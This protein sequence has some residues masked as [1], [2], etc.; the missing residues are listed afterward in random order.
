MDPVAA[1][2]V[3]VTRSTVSSALLKEARAKGLVPFWDRFVQ[4]IFPLKF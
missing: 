4:H 2:M 1:S 3:V